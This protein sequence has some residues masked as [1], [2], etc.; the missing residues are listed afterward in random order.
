MRARRGLSNVRKGLLGS[1]DERIVLMLVGVVV[2]VCSGLAAVALTDAIELLA[3]G[4]R[5]ASHHWWS[6]ALP[7][8]GAAVSSF[9]LIKVMREEAG[10][11]VPEVIYSVSR[12]GGL[13]RFRASFSRLISSC[14]TIGSGGSAGPEAPVVISGAAIGSRIARVFSFNERR[15]IALV[16]CGAAGAI[17]AIFN[18]P[19]AGI[20]FSIEVILGE[21]TAYNL[22]P[23]A[24]A[25][26]AGTEVSRVLRGNQIPF[27][28]PG[29][30]IGVDDLL[31]AAVLSVLCALASLCLTYLI[32]L[33]HNGF[34]KLKQADW[35]R[36]CLGGCLVGGLGL[37]IPSVLGEGY[38]LVRD[39]IDGT[40]P[41]GVLVILVI[42]AAKMVATSL[43]LGSGGSG[44]IFAPSLAVGSLVG[45][46]FHR[47]LSVLLPG[48]SLVGEGCFALLGMAGLV[49]GMLHA[50]LTGIF[51]V[52]EITGGYSVIL[53]L[54]IVSVVSATLCRT[55]QGASIYLQDLVK[56]G[57]LARPGSDTR[58]LAELEV[59][60]L[61]ERDCIVVE[62]SMSLG[63][64]VETVKQSRRN[65][66]AVCEHQGVGFLGMI[67]LDS[68]RAYLFDPGLY[69]AVVV[70]EIMEAN[71]VT[72]APTDDLAT[73]LGKMDREHVF[74][75]PVVEDGRFLGMVSK[76]TLLDQY[77]KELIVQTS[78]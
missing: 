37:V 48:A 75:L 35:W 23:I 57:L 41:R 39:A 78:D 45:L 30:T 32:Q 21:W 67:N 52:V 36:A 1:V 50:P 28:N 59:L 51:L 40:F 17:G 63:E 60:E 61:L 14:L 11:G 2:G 58:V 26:V 56:R 16:G 77:R 15:R 5:V 72:V 33:S 64:L 71:P 44:G 29:F 19:I 25:A 62:E 43:T 7:G 54:I 13:L 4:L 69:N 66:F 27:Q 46:G 73:V 12:R 10:H 47:C 6:F 31:A 38:H 74:S 34:D 3:S 20:V 9:F 70:G 8:I 24:I 22:V 18:A 49:G 65:H 42:V 53:P 55:W 68:I 76:G